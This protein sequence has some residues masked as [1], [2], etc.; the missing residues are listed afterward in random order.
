MNYVLEAKNLSL[1]KG[2]RNIFSI[3]SFSLIKGE[4]LALI[5]PNGAGKT[6]LL[7]TLALLE[8]PSGGIL[9]FNGEKITASR[10]ISLRRR[11]A[12]VFQEPLL[13]D[14]T[15]QQN[16]A[17]GLKIRKVPE[18]E[19]RLRVE[20]WMERLGIRHLSRHQARYLSGGEAQRASLARALVLEPEVLFL[21]EPFSALDY[22]TKNALL[23]DLSMIF[24]DTGVSALFVT[25]DYTE[26]PFLASNAAIM[27]EGRVIKSGTLREVFGV[28]IQRRENLIPWEGIV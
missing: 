14:T 18:K 3:E 7:L 23:N 19:A 9:L 27:H 15:V 12:V 24:K 26:I 22:S 21:D 11:M 2:G 6:S 28:E 25:H 8:R 20:L 16:I 4:V 1:I 5:G 13:L 10:V 17:T